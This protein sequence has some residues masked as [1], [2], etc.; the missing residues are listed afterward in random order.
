MHFWPTMGFERKE[1]V[2]TM[3]KNSWQL[4]SNVSEVKQSVVFLRQQE[5]VIFQRKSSFKVMGNA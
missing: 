4:Y 3:H 2:V 5:S 1:T